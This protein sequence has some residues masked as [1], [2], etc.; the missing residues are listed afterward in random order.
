MVLSQYRYYYNPNEVQRAHTSSYIAPG[1]PPPSQ[2]LQP[3][4][5]GQYGQWPEQGGYPV[6]YQAPAGSGGSSGGSKFN[7]NEIKTFIDRMGGIDGIVTSL[8]KVNGIIQNVQKMAPMIKLLAG[9]FIK[10]KAVTNDLDL[11]TPQRKRKKRRTSTRK[12]RGS[13]SS[14]RTSTQRRST[15]RRSGQRRPVQTKSRTNRKSYR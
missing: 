10:S 5:P 1:S 8:N 3:V 2:S 6:P 7:L 15:Q 4:N 11:D 14:S 12:R 13:A 9:S